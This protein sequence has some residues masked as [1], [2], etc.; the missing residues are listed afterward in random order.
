MQNQPLV[1]TA[2][3]DP[4]VI[5]LSHDVCGLKGFKC[6]PFR[7]L[8]QIWGCKGDQTWTGGVQGGGGCRGRGRVRASRVMVG[9]ERVAV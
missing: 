8:R 6:S 3:L 1:A 9:Q 5:R 2:Y 7:Y 4:L